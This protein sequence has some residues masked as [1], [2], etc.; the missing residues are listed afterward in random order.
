MFRFPPENTPVTLDPLASIA[1]TSLPDVNVASMP[2]VNIG[3]TPNVNIN[4]MPSVTI[5]SMPAVNVS[6]MP[7]VTLAGT[8]SVSLN[9]VGPLGST[10]SV[11]TNT[12][13]DFR[14]APSPATVVGFGQQWADKMVPEVQ[15][16][17]VYGVPLQA[18][19]YVING[20]ATGGSS[21]SGGTTHGIF[22]VN[23]ANT[24]GSA[25]A[26]IS[27]RRVR[28]RAGQGCVFMFTTVFS[29]PSA[30]HL[31]AAGA[32]SS[33]G[34]LMVGYYSNTGS[35]PT[36]LQL[37]RLTDGVARVV[38]VTIT[39]I[40]NGSTTATL[41]ID[42]QVFTITFTMNAVNNNNL[43]AIQLASQ[44]SNLYV[45]DINGNVVTLVERL[46]LGAWTGT[47]SLTGTGLTATVTTLTAGT[48]PTVTTL[49][50]SVWNGDRLDGT[51]PS[52][53]TINP[54]FGNIWRIDTQ[55]LGYG[56][57][58]L[59]NEISVNGATE[60]TR[61]H[62]IAHPNS[63]Q[64]VN[65]S[66]PSMPMAVMCRALAGGLS[67]V[68]MGCGSMCGYVTGEKYF[69]GPRFTLSNF[70]TVTTL[71]QN[72][73][74]LLFQ[75][76]GRK[77]GRAN[78]TVVYLKSW[79]ASIAG[80]TGAGIFKLIRTPTIT[81]GGNVISLDENVTSINADVTTTTGIAAAATPD[82]VLHSIV[83]APNSAESFVFSAEVTL[84]PGEIMAATWTPVS[85]P[86]G[87]FSSAQVSVN[88]SEDC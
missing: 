86:G 15:I 13:G 11:K 85:A 87:S 23:S 18:L 22:I 12:L 25:G 69:Y 26:I 70:T 53:V 43:A 51:G 79:T 36:E 35:A 19:T 81:V 73:V 60:W 54:L 16:D 17:G 46:P 39:G 2:N 48:A 3:N 8:S 68:Q 80:G 88:L 56:C 41:T 61:C 7:N 66:Q 9:A 71:S 77:L 1:V 72:S 58:T 6:S 21:W 20:G 84:Q 14:T 76:G 45:P 24:A 33:V 50:Q 28:Y 42:S 47:H 62:T 55:Y 57:I 65:L 59:W 82:K 4:N 49:G 31:Q 38:Q 10:L 75:N 83:C 5:S 74:V 44:I 40:A 52:G 78:Q 34:G 32:C 27:R 30:N 37:I 29:A 67:N 64:A 63:S